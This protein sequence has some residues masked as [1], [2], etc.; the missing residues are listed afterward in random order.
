MIQP[1]YD[2][3]EEPLC[4]GGFADVWKGQYQGLE[5]AVKVL[6]M[7]STNDLRQMRG[8]GHWWLP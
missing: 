5:V 6:R 4:R 7:Y 2:P 1:H 8:V 3:A